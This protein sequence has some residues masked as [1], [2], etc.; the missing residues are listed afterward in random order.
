[1][2]IIYIVLFLIIFLYFNCSLIEPACLIIKN[3]SCYTIEVTL[4]NGNKKKIEIEKNKGDFVLLYG[5]KVNLNVSI[6]SI[7][8]SKDYSISLNY[9]EKKEF[10]FS[11]K[12]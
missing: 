4:D 7:G 11:T 12:E 8:F 9:M 6:E 3:E 5:N 2:K 1:M 10:V